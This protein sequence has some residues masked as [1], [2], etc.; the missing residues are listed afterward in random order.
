MLIDL[1]RPALDAV[2]AGGVAGKI[3][4]P[5]QDLAS[6]RE[7]DA[8]KPA[9]QDDLL[10]GRNDEPFGALGLSHHAGG[11][12]CR[13]RGRLDFGSGHNAQHDRTAWISLLEGKHDIAADVRG[14]KA[15]H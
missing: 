3:S 9:A 5:N 1:D 14:V 12:C 8:G 2:Y 11:A 6:V 7:R 4:A 15:D 10:V 13:Q